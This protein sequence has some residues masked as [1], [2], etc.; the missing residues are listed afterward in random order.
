MIPILQ[1]FHKKE[2]KI[3]PRFRFPAC[4]VEQF[5]CRAKEP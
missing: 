4:Y 3:P 1:D 2:M 5:N